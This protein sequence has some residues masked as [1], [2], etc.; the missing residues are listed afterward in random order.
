MI[1][2][3]T[4]IPLDSISPLVYQKLRVICGFFFSMWFITFI[5]LMKR[6]NEVKKLKNKLNIDI[7]Y[8]PK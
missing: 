1:E 3:I 5:L 4:F 2:E 8:N 6:T 7:N